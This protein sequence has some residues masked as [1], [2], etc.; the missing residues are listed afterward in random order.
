MSPFSART[1]S[2]L[3]RQ[4]SFHKF[5]KLRLYFA[6][7]VVLVVLFFARSSNHGFAFG[8]PV[9]LLGEGIR[10][11]SHGYLRKSRRLA[12][13]G[14][15]AYVRNPLYV[16][17]FF[18]GLGFC[19]ILWHP[20]VV[21]LYIVGFYALYWVT[22]KGEEQRLLHKFKDDYTHYYKHVPRFIPQLM[23]YSKSTRSK[24]A[25]H[26]ILGHGEHITIFAII[27]FVLGLFLRQEVVQEGCSLLDEQILWVNF[28]VISVFILLAIS[29]IQR[30]LK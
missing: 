4:F 14:P 12:V 2:E 20:I 9:I 7:L 23:P 25:S 5:R 29:L 18:L 15:Y 22:V 21:S 28:V 10:I 1:P 13:S 8:I 3:D 24:F 19:I 26:R 17:N 16:G 27:L 11:W 30:R 6:W